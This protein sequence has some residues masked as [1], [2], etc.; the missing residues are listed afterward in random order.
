MRTVSGARMMLLSSLLMLLAVCL[1]FVPSMG[2]DEADGSTDYVEGGIEYTWDGNYPRTVKVTGVEDDHVLES[3][4]VIPDSITVSGFDYDVVGIG[5]YAFENQT[6]LKEVTVGRNVKSIGIYAFT[7]TSLETINLSYGIRS[8]GEGAFTETDLKEI[9]LTQPIW[10]IQFGKAYIVSGTNEWSFVSGYDG[11]TLEGVYTSSEFEQST[12]VGSE[13]FGPKLNDEGFTAYFKYNY[14]YNVEHY[15]MDEDG[16]GYSLESESTQMLYGRGTTE[17]VP[18]TFMGYDSVPFDQESI[19]APTYYPQ[20][21]KYVFTPITVKIYYDLDLMSVDIPEE[22]VQEYGAGDSFTP[23]DTE[24]TYRNGVKGSLQVTEDMVQGFSTLKSGEFKATVKFRGET[25]TF[26]YIVSPVT[27]DLWIGGVQITN[28]E[29]V[30]EDDDG[31]TASFD[32]TTNTLTLDDFDVDSEETGIR[33]TMVEQLD[34]I[35]KGVNNIISAQNGIDAVTLSIVGDGTLNIDSG[36]VGIKIG[37]PYHTDIRGMSGSERLQLN[38]YSG[39]NGIYRVFVAGDP[40]E[41]SESTTFQYCEMVLAGSGNYGIHGGQGTYIEDCTVD[42]EGYGTGIFSGGAAL[43]YFGIENST[44]SIRCA[45]GLSGYYADPVF[46]NSRV[47]I[48]SKI[49]INVRIGSIGDITLQDSDLSIRYLTEG[50]PTSPQ[51]FIVNGDSSIIIAFDHEN[52]MIDNNVELFGGIVDIIVKDPEGGIYDYV[53]LAGGESGS[54][55]TYTRDNFYE[56]ANSTETQL[57]M[58]KFIQNEE[59]YH[60]EF[61]PMLTVSFDGGGR[62]GSMDPIPTYEGG[63]VELPYESGFTSGMGEVFIG[64]EDASGKFYLPDRTIVVTQDTVLSPVYGELVPSSIS[65]SGRAAFV[66]GDELG[67]SDLMVTIGY[68]DGKSTAL[69]ITDE[70]FTVSG[71]STEAYV[72]DDQPGTATVEYNGLSCTFDYTVAKL[73]QSTDFTLVRM[74]L[75]EPRGTLQV[76]EYFDHGDV[77]GR[78]YFG[79]T[80]GELTIKL[81]EKGDAEFDYDEQ[82]MTI[83]NVSK[84]GTMTVLV[85]R[86]ADD[87]YQEVSKEFQ[88]TVQKF[89]FIN[90]A[91]L[92]NFLE[93]SSTEPISDREVNIS[94]MHSEDAIVTMEIVEGGSATATIEDGVVSVTNLGTDGTVKVNVAVSGS[95]YYS[96]S[97]AT[98]TLKFSKLTG[99][100]EDGFTIPSGLTA[101][102]GQTTEDIAL[103]EHWSWS[104]VVTFETSGD[105]QVQATYTPEDEDN[106][107]AY[108]TLL[109][110]S[111][112]K[113]A[114]TVTLSQTEFTYDDG[115]QIDFTGLVGGVG[116]GDVSYEITE[117]NG[118]EFEFSDGIVRN[119]SIAGGSFDIVISRASTDQYGPVVQKFTIGLNKGVQEITVT[120]DVDSPPFDTPYEVIVTGYHGALAYDVS[121]GNATFTGNVLNATGAGTVVYT[122]NAAETDLYE[123]DVE[124]CSVTF[125]KIGLTVSVNDASIEYGSVPEFTVT[126]QGLVEG[127]ILGDILGDITFTCGYEQYD[128]VGTY[129][130]NVSGN[131]VHDD[132]DITYEPGELTVVAK[133]ISASISSATSAYGAELAQLVATTEGIVNGDTD[134]YTLSTTATTSSG[135]GSYDIIG[136]INDTNYAVKFLNGNGAYTITKALIEPPVVESKIYTGEKLVADIPTSEVYD[137]VSNDGGIVKGEYDVVLCLKDAVNYGWKEHGDVNITLKFSILAGYN[138]WIQGPSINPWSYGDRPNELQF[139]AMHG[140]GT[141]IVEHR[142]TGTDEW[143]DGLPTDAGHYDVRVTIPETLDYAALSSTV[144][145]T[146]ERADPD[147]EISSTL[148]AT[149]GQTLIE[150]MLPSDEGGVWTW[151]LPGDT[152]VGDVGTRTFPALFTPKDLV[153]YNL[154]DDYQV[155]VQVQMADSIINTEPQ[156]STGLIYDGTSQVLVQAGSSEGGVMQYRLG[157][158]NGWSAMVPSATGAGTYTVY[159]KVVGD[160]NHNDTEEK[161]LTVSISKKLVVV[162][163]NDV[164]VEQFGSIPYEIG[165]TVSGLVDGDVIDDAPVVSLESDVDTDVCG[166]Y[167]INVSGGSDPNYELQYVGGTLTIF[168]HTEHDFTGSWESDGTGHWHVCSIVGC[169]ETDTKV[170]HE[171]CDATCESAAVCDICQ[172]ECGPK[173]LENHVGGTEVR[174]DDEDYSGDTYCLGCNNILE[175]GY[176][177][178]DVTFTG[179]G[180][181]EVL[182][183]TGEGGTVDGGFPLT[184]REGYTFIGWF[185]GGSDTPIVES[186]MFQEDTVLVGQWTVNQYTITFDSDGGSEVEP[187]TQDYGT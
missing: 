182:R 53:V 165:Y 95:P 29:N 152:S 30:I 118:V 114:S 78:Y 97:S 111:V 68:A 108:T 61:H 106:Y 82:S 123:S 113:S 49:G 13:A 15:L 117:R 112:G 122:V 31:G 176:Y 14:L 20:Q 150:V 94:L 7:N 115:L 135:V 177:I 46:E 185:T 9:V 92:R 86:A 139:E 133:S 81:L 178:Y 125:A 25:A 146:V 8:I 57:R 12:R 110:V 103:P 93:L 98:F 11:V 34:I 43:R 169:D 151:I 134:V 1:V 144:Q 129:T 62:E 64:W 4:L 179:E 131:A 168:E 174:D 3:E 74:S 16:E 147:S 72:P 69:H 157:A 149:Y 155:T 55:T 154:K 127:D 59:Q 35:V 130:V 126:S 109:I 173:D 50:I 159:Y 96:D 48:I 76:D 65:V 85:T 137:V 101:F 70:L 18:K 23:F 41:R 91:T 36:G 170:E 37:K 148:V 87:I 56:V 77:G 90:E 84:P 119:I 156:A 132:Y 27:Y 162:T 167:I 164:E 24:I 102:R 116:D 140:D 73:L 142:V 38:I 104:E 89:R 145:L 187:I 172:F 163:V 63:I 186:D 54:L 184:D 181:T 153:N 32:I 79:S 60:Y 26:T 160:S 58:P 120:G 33:S 2:S 183:S 107:T 40:N 19:R 136:T 39:G 143:R 166:T 28:D 67:G 141:A 180:F 171:P 88:L 161:D 175:S 47:D 75:D 44:V 5:D 45:S 21:M 17:A 158:G 51:D 128:D 124:E 100:H 71:F 10:S 105:I 80:Q 42:V 66:I 121:S 83:S 138:Q 22:F 99:D 52:G 6:G